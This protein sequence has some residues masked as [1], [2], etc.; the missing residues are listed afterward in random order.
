MEQYEEDVRSGMN[1]CKVADIRL[2]KIVHYKRL[3][4]SGVQGDQGKGGG[5]H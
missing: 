4:R 2:S 5:D 1:M 3:A